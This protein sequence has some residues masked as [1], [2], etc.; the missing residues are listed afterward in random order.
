[1]NRNDNYVTVVWGLILLAVG[2][3]L[4]LQ[5]LGWLAIGWSFLWMLLALAGGAAFVVMFV[6][7][8]E[9]WWAAIPGFTLLG[10]GTLMALDR[11]STAAIGGWGGSI[12]L[13]GI[14]LGF[15][16]VFLRKRENWWAVIPG[17]VLM[18]LATVAGLSEVVSGLEIGGIFFLGLA[19]T[20]SLVYVL[21]TPEGRMT[22][23]VIPAGILFALGVLIL[24]GA[25]SVINFVWPVALILVGSYLLYRSLWLRTS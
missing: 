10:M 4:L 13:G 9:H 8:R 12:F 2:V 7:R 20:F 11:Y 24:I 5:T 14:S 3:L 18:T 15:W 16:A 1:M 22:W 19:L 23:A 6:T 25:G 21:P 17:G